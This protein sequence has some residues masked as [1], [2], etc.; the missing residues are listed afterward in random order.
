MSGRGGGDGRR[1]LE[2]RERETAQIENVRGIV[3][4]YFGQCINCKL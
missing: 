1:G 2:E 4:G 3:Y